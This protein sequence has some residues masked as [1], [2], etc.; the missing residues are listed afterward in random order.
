MHLMLLV[1]FGLLFLF[2]PDWP[3]G[4]A[5]SA[6]DVVDAAAITLAACDTS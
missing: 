6:G 4:V 3:S 2:L 1:V 5:Q